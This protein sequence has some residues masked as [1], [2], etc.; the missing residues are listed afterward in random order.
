M[1]YCVDTVEP[2]YISGWCFD[3]T[4]LD[5]NVTLELY[6]DHQKVSEE[7]ADIHRQDLKEH[8]MHPT[9]DAGFHFVLG[10]R[11][12]T[13]R[14]HIEIM[15]KESGYGLSLG[16]ALTTFR[17]QTVSQSSFQREKGDCCILHVGMHMTD[18]FTMQNNLSNNENN[19]NFFYI[20]LKMPGYNMPLYTL[21][22]DGTKT[23]R[24]IPVPDY[25][26]QGTDSLQKY[27]DK[28]FRTFVEDDAQGKTCV[29]SCAGVSTMKRDE[30][31]ALRTYLFG[32]FEKVRVVAYVQT[33]IAHMKHM[34]ME[35]VKRG[36]ADFASLHLLYPHYRDRLENLDDVWG[37]ENVFLYPFEKEA[38][39]HGNIVDDLLMRNHLKVKNSQFRDGDVP[40]SLEA[41]SFLYLFY[42]YSPALYGR[43][44]ASEHTNDMLLT[45][46]ESFGTKCFK[47]SMNV[48]I[49]ALT[50]QSNQDTAA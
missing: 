38:L 24:Y 25:S 29:L 8:G 45:Y 1:K 11:Y 16:D 49:T 12:L 26:E 42:K 21:F 19:V 47:F 41:A 13:E 34:F 9:G 40:L 37:K 4:R 48:F 44:K 17:Q 6:I 46:M 23:G 14:N 15:V 22:S 28:Q 10:D 18:S 3:E 20:D 36:S 33:P 39:S 27:I 2:Q 5:Q 43:E 50:K 7:K 32:F 31:S 35:S 30:L